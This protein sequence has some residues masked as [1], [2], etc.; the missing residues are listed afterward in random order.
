MPAPET[1]R[2]Y[3]DDLSDALGFDSALCCRVR[4]EVEDHLHEAV[5][6]GAPE[7]DAVTRFGPVRDIAAQF[8]EASL[9]VQTKTAGITLL[10]GILGVYFAMRGRVAWWGVS[11]ALRH[12]LIAAAFV[13]VMRVAFWVA[14]L[15]GLLC[16]AFANRIPGARCELRKSLFWVVLL[17]AGATVAS[18]VGVATDIVLVGVRISATAWTASTLLPGVMVTG[19]ILLSAF[20]VRE[21]WVLAYRVSAGS[22][23]IDARS[24]ASRDGG[25][26]FR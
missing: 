20:L 5:A 23:L 21:C 26:G 3:L 9:T 1:I 4:A 19:E 18:V 24:G 11:D 8:A 12:S 22:R 15:A 16:W 13:P 6:D 2:A 17:G 7:R 10:L 14:L 25:P